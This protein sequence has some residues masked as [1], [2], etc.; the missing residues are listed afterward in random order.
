[1]EKNNGIKIKSESIRQDFFQK[2]GSVKAVL[3]RREMKG[4]IIGMT[5]MLAAFGIANSISKDVHK[6]D[7]A[8]DAF[9]ASEVDGMAFGTSM[10]VPLAGLGATMEDARSISLDDV[11]SLNIIINNNKCSDAFFSDVCR[12][13]EDDDIHFSRRGNCD[14]I[15]VD[16]AVVITLDELYLSGS[17]MSF[18]APYDN[19]RLGESDALA[20]AMETGFKEGGFA[21]DGVSSGKIGYKEAKTGGFQ[22]KVPTLT[23]DAI[24]SSKNTSF[25]TISFGTDIPSSE[26]VA[27]GIENGLARFIYYNRNKPYG[28]DLIYRV[29][30]GN[31]MGDVEGRFYGNSA[32]VINSYNGLSDNKSNDV[33]MDDTLLNPDI[34]KFEAFNQECKISL[35]MDKANR[36]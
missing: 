8:R 21:T 5:G 6:Y 24:D 3:K 35:G 14:G 9:V 19:E 28:E 7:D 36:Y 26:E 15:D 10:D 30:A 4:A 2:L 17:G 20:L 29:E 12:K 27:A 31:V 32:T 23:E 16:N 22:T 34:A 25:V 13:L 33:Y 11:N 18:F 1:M